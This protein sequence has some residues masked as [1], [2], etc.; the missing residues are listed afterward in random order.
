MASLSGITIWDGATLQTLTSDDGLPSDSVRDIQADAQGRIWIAT[1]YGIA[2]RGDDGAW[3]TAAPSTSGLAE[4]RIAALAVRGAPTLPPPIAAQ[5]VEITGQV[6]QGG[7][8]VPDTEVLLCSERGN[9]FF[10]ESPCEGQ[11]F[12]ALTRTDANGEFRFTEAPLGTLG[13]AARDT[14]GQWVIFLDGVR[15]LDA[16]AEIN[17]GSVE[18]GEG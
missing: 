14:E 8:P 16:G 11:P 18:L 13:L 15:A 6:L 17:L 1:D 10:N 4:S 5:T 2:V 7:E 9:T 12:S 3:S